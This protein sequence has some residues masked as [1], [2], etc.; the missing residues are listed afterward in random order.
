MIRVPMLAAVI[1]AKQNPRGTKL[2]GEIDRLKPGVP[3]VPND[4]DRTAYHLSQPCVRAPIARDGH[5]GDVWCYRPNRV[6]GRIAPTLERAGVPV[7]SPEPA[8]GR[9]EHF[10]PLEKLI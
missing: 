7:L 6:V 8:I 4:T 2:R 1:E 3:S 10:R 5:R 9:I